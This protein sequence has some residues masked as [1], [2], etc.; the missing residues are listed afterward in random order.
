MNVINIIASFSK[1]SRHSLIC[2]W[3]SS[4]PF[5]ELSEIRRSFSKSWGR[6][7]SRTF[8]RQV[9]RHRIKSRK[10]P[11]SSKFAEW[12]RSTNQGPI[13][14]FLL[15][16]RNTAFSVDLLVGLTYIFLCMPRGVPPSWC[17]ASL[18]RLYPVYFLRP[19]YS[20]ISCNLSFSSSSSSAWMQLVKYCVLKQS[21]L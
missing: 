6:Y 5:N 7:L 20:T 17:G 11:G 1:S 14:V 4:E 9:T 10:V 12:R 8:S 15:R 13:I 2:T 19:R 16:D 21:C 18:L 3:N